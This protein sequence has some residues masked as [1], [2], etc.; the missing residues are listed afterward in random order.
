MK[1]T[2][3]HLRTIETHTYRVNHQ[4]YR[5]EIIDTPTNGRTATVRMHRRAEPIYEFSNVTD[6]QQICDFLDEN[7]LTR[8]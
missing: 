3:I 4:T 5:I 2:R 7:P 8:R 1:G 6:V